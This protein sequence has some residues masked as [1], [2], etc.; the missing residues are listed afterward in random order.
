MS[1]NKALRQHLLN[2]LKGGDAH[3]GF[4]SAIKN[5]PANLRGKRPKG[6]EHS[7]WGVLEH[8]RI[9]QWDI[10]E[11]SR[12]PGHRSPEFPG[13]YWPSTQSPASEKA[14]DQSVQGFRKDL[15]A[16]CELVA[17]EST[18]LLAVIPHGDGQSVLREALLAADHNAYHL[19]ELVLLRRILGTWQ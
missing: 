8:L 1:N 11:F 14:W 7:A 9:A 6:A 12:N 4:E 17:N 16:L 13:G 10:L 5:F 3:V 15:E 18:D 19:G 2:L